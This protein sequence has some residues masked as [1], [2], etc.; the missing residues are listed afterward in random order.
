MASCRQVKSLLQS[1]VDDELNK[2]KALILEKHFAECHRCA[3][4]LQAQKATSA[5]LYEAYGEHRL[6]GDLSP[7]VMA[8]LPE[9]ELTHEEVERTNWR[10]KHPKRWSDSLRYAIPAFAL[11]LLP[12]LALTIA[13]SWPPDDPIREEVVGMVT[14]AAASAEHSLD[15]GLVYAPV[16][17]EEF[18]HRDEW[19]STG[20]VGGLLISLRG[21]TELKVDANT[22][23]K[24]RNNRLI[25]VMEGRIWLDVSEED[26]GQNFRVI[27]PSGKVTVYGTIFSVAVKTESTLVV[28]ADGEVLVEDSEAGDDWALVIP[29]NSAEVY[30]DDTPLKEGFAVDTNVAMAWTNAILADNQAYAEFLAKIKINEAITEPSKKMYRFALNP[31]NSVKSITIKWKPQYYSSGYSSYYVFVFDIEGQEVLFVGQIGGDVFTSTW[32][33]EFTLPIPTDKPI[34]GVDGIY[35]QLRADQSTGKI[36]SD[37]SAAEIAEIAAEAK[38]VSDGVQ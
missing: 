16:S 7:K 33:D 15:D 38:V 28:V 34:T 17:L 22:R 9:M 13:Y 36:K 8:H 23:L 6:C 19:Y 32:R 1:F 4:L 37:F 18:V 26:S 31:A 29:G 2:S 24:I 12:V 21:H 3:A 14:Y 30:R 35:I 10:M 5:V 20:E 11:L 27:T 25:D